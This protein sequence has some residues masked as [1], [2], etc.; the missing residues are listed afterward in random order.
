MIISASVFTSKSQFFVLLQN[1]LGDLFKLTFVLE[2]SAVVD[3]Q[4]RYFDT[5]APSESLIIIKAGFLFA[6]C[7]RGTSF[8]FQI[9]AL[10]DAM[11]V[12]ATK[13]TCSHYEPT[14]LSNLFL[15]HNLS[16]LASIV[17]GR[18]GNY[19]GSSA[20]EFLT[21]TAAGPLS[22]LNLSRYGIEGTEVASTELPATPLR[23]WS[24]KEHNQDEYHAFIAVAFVNA[25]AVLRVG[26]DITEVP[27][28]GFLSNQ[29]TQFVHQFWDSSVIQVTDKVVRHIKAADKSVTEWT[30][31]SLIKMAAA[32]TH[33]LM[34]A[35]SSNELVYFV[36]ESAGLVEMAERKKVSSAV[37]TMCLEPVE[38]GRLRSKFVAIACEDSTL[39]IYTLEQETL[40]DT[41]ITVLGDVANSVF[42]A[43][44]NEAS[45][46][47]GLVAHVGLRNS[48]YLIY[49][50]A[51]NGQLVEGETPRMRYLGGTS[52]K[53]HRRSSGS[54]LLS[55]GWS[56]MI[57]LE[58]GHQNKLSPVIIDSGDVSSPMAD[59]TEFNS[60]ESR[61]FI[62]IGGNEL[63]IFSV[64]GDG[65]TSGLVTKSLA[66]RCP[67]KK[68]LPLNCP[69]TSEEGPGP[70]LV[71]ILETGPS[72]DNRAMITSSSSSSFTKAEGL[73]NTA[74]DIENGDEDEEQ[75]DEQIFKRLHGPYDEQGL[76]Q[77][78]VQFVSL[79]N[80]DLKVIE[81]LDF[82]LGEIICAGAFMA[83]HDKPGMYL[84]ISVKTASTPKPSSFIYTFQMTSQKPTLIHKTDVSDVGVALSLC[85]YHGR[86]LVGFSPFYEATEEH[87]SSSSLSSLRMY[88]L[89][90][91][92]LL[93]KCHTS[94]PS[95]AGLLKIEVPSPS[96]SY[97][98]IVTD[99]K[100]SLTFLTYR[101]AE[102]AFLLIADDV[103]QR[104][105]AA[106]L[107][108]D[109]N[110]A[111]VADKFGQVSVL[112]LQSSL[113]HEID[114]DDTGSKLLN[115]TNPVLI[116]SAPYKLDTII[117]HYVGDT[118][119][120]FDKIAL[121]A[122][123]TPSL[124]YFTLGGSIHAL[125]PLA[126][127]SELFF[128]QKL[129]LLLRDYFTKGT[130]RPL[131]SSASS[132]DGSG[133]LSALHSLG[134]LGLAGNEHVRY[135]SS[136]QPVRN[137]I[138]GS[139]IQAFGTLSSGVQH[140]IAHELDLKPSQILRKIDDFRL[141]H[142]GF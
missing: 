50:L 123:A 93:L 2:Q 132:Q 31:A 64:S 87:Q 114:Y 33:Q 57:F 20:P 24:F 5:I 98:I 90:L 65:D 137:C 8:L 62:L 28:S 60:A 136:F 11:P 72:Y 53:F 82:P 59:L 45:E 119:L 113:S 36:L 112:R 58:H 120:A 92:K 39:R 14:Y 37:T 121:V 71:A 77:S 19:F 94:L 118:V 54:F 80:G 135:R 138:D 115:P 109:Y 122:N 55:C 16:S 56:N 97:R 1:E 15:V 131:H 100:E 79:H 107:C 61:G 110:T 67:P 30:S 96:N 7:C 66:L 46:E 43:R 13:D 103:G 81:D 47:A 38:E 78:L 111:V 12:L 95:C 133:G 117:E 48:V 70:C 21:L 108:L 140:A 27:D 10:A 6:A 130:D 40:I 68:I 44:R 75:K 29:V 83:F 99:V 76:F 124:L 52:L 84:V 89:G 128:F 25:T 101:P 9:V 88:D 125:I 63:K 41:S 134:I 69:A 73:S 17:D 141:L 102:N 85:P 51:F 35:L 105:S 116:G 142:V 104:W 139:L 26:D 3:I 22:R 4:L 106:S 74:M 32:N 86:V 23:I 42:L 18:V 129:E 91:K 49:S 126:S 127:R 34:L